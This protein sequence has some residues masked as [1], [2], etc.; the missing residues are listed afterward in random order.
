MTF[1]KSSPGTPPARRSPQAGQTC[2]WSEPLR[3]WRRLQPSPTALLSGKLEYYGWTIRLH[4]SGDIQRK[5]SRKFAMTS[6]LA[7]GLLAWR[8][9]YRPRNRQRERIQEIARPLPKRGRRYP[10]EIRCAGIILRIAVLVI[11]HLEITVAV[12]VT[13]HLEITVAVLVICHL[14]I[15]VAVLVIWYLTETEDLLL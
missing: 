3:P 8:S 4:F 2:W 12:L 13:W 14:E 7:S 1:G 9:F 10:K 6:W 5:W 11:C 15:T